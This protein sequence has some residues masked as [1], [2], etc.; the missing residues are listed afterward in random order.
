MEH[1]LIYTRR[2]DRGTTSCADGVVVRKDSSVIEA[3]GAIDELSC[4]V[5]LLAAYEVRFRDELQAVQ[6]CL[7]AVGAYLSGVRMP[8]FFP[9]AED[10]AHLEALID[11]SNVSFNGFLL[12]GG[13]VSAAQAHV[14]RAVC[15]RAERHVVAVNGVA[16]VPYLN[17]LSDYFFVLSMKLN[18]IYKVEEIKL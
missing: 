18:D 14:C 13:H 8:R 11:E 7:F 16:A 9:T 15:R 1:S 6:C 17:R 12:P 10:V 5:G 2:G 4:H 3:C